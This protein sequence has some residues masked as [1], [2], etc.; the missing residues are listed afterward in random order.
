MKKT[1][2]DE[3]TSLRNINNTNDSIN[4][5]Q[6]EINDATRDAYLYAIG[7]IVAVMCAIMAH[8]WGFHTALSYGM[9]VRIIATGAI[10]HKV[11]G[12]YMNFLDRCHIYIFCYRF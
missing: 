6:E 10:Y 9:Q 5:K 2:E 3:L 1:L 7:L 11:C 8:A 12:A 4:S